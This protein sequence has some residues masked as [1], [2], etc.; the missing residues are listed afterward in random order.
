MKFTRAEM[1]IQYDKNKDGTPKE[2]PYLWRAKEGRVGI[3]DALDDRLPI[4]DFSTDGSHWVGL[5]CFENYIGISVAKYGETPTIIG[6]IQ[7]EKTDDTSSQ[8][9]EEIR[10]ISYR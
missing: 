5:A 7:I 6:A 4:I 10:L 9:D 3:S 1:F 2:K 8:E